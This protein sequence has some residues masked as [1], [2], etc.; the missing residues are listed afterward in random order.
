MPHG[1]NIDLV[2]DCAIHHKVDLPSAPRSAEGEPANR[3]PHSVHTQLHTYF[4]PR[5]LLAATIWNLAARHGQLDLTFA[6][7][8]FPS[9]YGELAPRAEHLM[10]A[11]TRIAVLVAALDDIRGGQ[12]KRPSRALPRFR[13][14]GATARECGV[15]RGI[16]QSR[17]VERGLPS[18]RRR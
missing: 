12:S 9:G 8:G 15:R 5:S 3:I 11:G 17:T 7:S 14:Q 6:P 2:A 1:M 10:V 13:A 18:V 4:T 16:G